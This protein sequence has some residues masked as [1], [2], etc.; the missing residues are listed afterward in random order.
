[1][2]QW[3]E[4]ESVFCASLHPFW[5]LYS[6]CLG[7][8]SR[9]DGFVHSLQE[10]EGAVNIW[11]VEERLWKARLQIRI[12]VGWKCERWD[13]FQIVLSNIWQTLHSTAG[14]REDLNVSTQKYRWAKSDKT[15][16][17]SLLWMKWSNPCNLKWNNV[18]S[19]LSCFIF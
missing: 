10:L 7:E 16:A 1:M 9:H 12:E 8:S 17:W 13:R 3:I 4:P 2:W 11:E 18:V 15:N 5:T 19:K 14:F 6:F